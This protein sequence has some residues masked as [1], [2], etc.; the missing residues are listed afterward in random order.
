M[1]RNSGSRSAWKRIC[2]DYGVRQVIFEIKNYD[3]DLG[4]YEF[5]QMASYLKDSYGRLGFIV[6]R[7]KNIHLEGGKE[8]DWVREIWSDKKLIIKLN[9]PYLLKMLTKLRN[10]QK[11]DEPDSSMNFGPR[12]PTLP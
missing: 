1:G 4:P 2:D 11:H 9:A 5:R 3:T 12:F 8:L 6:N 7:S 10:P